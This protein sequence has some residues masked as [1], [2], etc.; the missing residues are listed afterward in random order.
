M[1][2]T[3]ARMGFFE[4]LEELRSRLMRTVLALL[5]A[6]G[7]LFPFGDTMYGFIARPLV[8][9]LPE[10]AKMVFINPVAPFFTYLKV[11]LVAALLVCVPYIIYELWRFIAPGLYAK[12]KKLALPFV[13]IATA[14]FYIGVCFA[15]FIVFPVI[16]R[17][18]IVT[19]PASNIEPMI[20]IRE[21]VSLVMRLG[22]AFGAIFET[23][24][25][26]IF[27]GLLGIVDTTFLKKGRRYF[28]VI[29]F[30]IGAILSP[31]DIVSQIFIAAPLLI[32]Y[33]ASIR[34]LAVIEKR[35]AREAEELENI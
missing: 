11:S 18:F 17:F 21:H 27:L 14:L 28:V 33:E 13:A 32:L 24:I 31:P 7:I 35:R 30:L 16:F 25:I 29:S 4:H 23:P 2:D 1:T 12:E 10:G 3:G 9:F 22:L 20:D 5:V 6:F 19:V 15:Y 34:A 26:I 8:K